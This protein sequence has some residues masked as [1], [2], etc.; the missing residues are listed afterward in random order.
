MLSTI[1]TTG[2]QVLGHETETPVSYQKS[3]VFVL[4]EPHCTLFNKLHLVNV[5]I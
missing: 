4:G 3:E 1:S 5:S 2:Y